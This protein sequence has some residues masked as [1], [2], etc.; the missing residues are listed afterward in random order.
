[1]NETNETLIEQ[2][3]VSYRSIA[4]RYGLIGSLISIALGLVLYVAGLV[5]FAD[6]N[7]PGS[8]ASTVLNIAITIAVFVLAVKQHRDQDLGG[9]ITFG[10]A[11]GV[12][13][14][15]GLV[16]AVIGTIWTFLFVQVIDPTILETVADSARNDMLEQGMDDSQIEEAWP[17]VSM[18]I[19]GPAMAFFA[20]LFSV[21][22]SVIFGLIVAA[23]MQKKR[24]ESL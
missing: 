23:V 14:L 12:A 16:M 6:N 8:I 18:F 19:S 10:R 15:T 4:L 3:K 17:M 9:F 24:P 13:F 11:F 7:S 1:M 2:P 20:F 21:I 22:G 5:D